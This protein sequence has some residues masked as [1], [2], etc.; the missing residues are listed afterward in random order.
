MVEIL[1]ELFLD[2]YLIEPLW[3]VVVYNLTDIATYTLNMS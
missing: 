1:S 2:Y 3:S